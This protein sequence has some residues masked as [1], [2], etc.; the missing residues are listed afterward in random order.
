MEKILPEI[1]F[2]GDPNIRHAVNKG[3]LH[4]I[5]SK[6]YTPNKIDGREDIMRRHRF[7]ILSHLFPEGIISHRSALEGGFTPDGTIFFNL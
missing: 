7:L 6:I 3:I 5:A 2:G 1:V 4:K